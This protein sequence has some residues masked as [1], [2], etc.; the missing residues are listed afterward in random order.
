MLGGI[1]SA[2][3]MVP[4]VRP[5]A[6]PYHQGP[7]HLQANRLGQR[8][9]GANDVLLFHGSTLVEQWMCVN[10][11]THSGLTARGRSRPSS[12]S[13]RTLAEEPASTESC[14]ALR[15]RA[16]TPDIDPT[17]DLFPEE[18]SSP[19]RRR[20][21]RLLVQRAPGPLRARASRLGRPGV[22]RSGEAAARMDVS[23]KTFWQKIRR[24][25][26][27][28]QQFASE[29]DSVTGRSAARES[30]R[31]LARNTL[32]IPCGH[33]PCPVGTAIQRRRL[34]CVGFS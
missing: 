18:L 10:G 23:R 31:P 27:D 14:P 11:P 34:R 5:V 25:G 3:A 22:R 20:S 30:I 1:C 21:L 2:S 17:D 26:I 33:P 13:M 32:Q 4:G 16:R 9:E 8:C 19:S 29:R 28:H 12:A 7:E 24:R 15:R 6:A